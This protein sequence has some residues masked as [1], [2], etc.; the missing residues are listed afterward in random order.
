VIAKK[1]EAH[2]YIPAPSHKK[3]DEAGIKSVLPLGGLFESALGVALNI[4]V[5]QLMGALG[6]SESEMAD[7]H[8]N[9]E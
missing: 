7:R 9:L 2:V 6:V 4:F 5:V 3:Q 1:A 8:A